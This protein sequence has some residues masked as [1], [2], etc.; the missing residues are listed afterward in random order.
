MHLGP[1]PVALI[2]SAAGNACCTWGI[3]ESSRSEGLDAGVLRAAAGML[4]FFAI[5]L[6]YLVIGFGTLF[7][8]TPEALLSIHEHMRG[9]ELVGLIGMWGCFAA[10]LEAAAISLLV[11]RRER[12]QR[13]HRA[14][15]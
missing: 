1:I 11:M 7:G 5:V 13:T 10:A 14:K 6:A 15:P 9:R 4:F 12:R 8:R 3:F 2:G